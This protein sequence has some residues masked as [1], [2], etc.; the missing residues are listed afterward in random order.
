MATAAID[1][2]DLLEVRE[3]FRDGRPCLKGTGIT[4]LTIANYHR[5]GL[6]AE[7]LLEAFPHASLAGIHAA[8]TYYYAHQRELDEQ[9]E[10]DVRRGEEQARALGAELI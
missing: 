3:G 6:G 8:L 5:T 10:A 9:Y 4:V 1:L 2:N 7:E